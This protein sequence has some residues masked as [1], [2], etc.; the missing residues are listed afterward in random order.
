MKLHHAIGNWDSKDSFT[1]CGR[2][3]PPEF[4]T[5]IIEEVTC[6]SRL[7]AMLSMNREILNGIEQSRID[8]ER[9]IKI[10]E[11]RLESVQ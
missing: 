1:D 11:E 2:I 7:N 10:I 8:I 9:D 4:A 6:K 3:V 5:D